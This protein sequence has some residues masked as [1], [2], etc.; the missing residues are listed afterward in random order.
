MGSATS[1]RAMPDAGSRSRRAASVSDSRI[2]PTIAILR[3]MSCALLLGG[4]VSA[5]PLG[6]QSDSARRTQLPYAP[7]GL[8]FGAVEEGARIFTPARLLPFDHPESLGHDF[9]TVQQLHASEF[10]V[11]LW[12]GERIG[13]RL[14]PTLERYPTEPSRTWP[15]PEFR[16]PPDSAALARARRVRHASAKSPLPG[17]RAAVF[18]GPALVAFIVDTRGMSL[19]SRHMTRATA[20]G[21]DVTRA[22]FLAAIGKAAPREGA[23]LVVVLWPR[24][25]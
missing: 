4:L 22:E 18:D 15:Y 16:P 14:W 19:A 12:L 2:G 9:P 3:V 13:L 1:V 20:M 25:P 6:A 21:L 24:E 10:P 17:L 23:G 7:V 5:T 8:F 11:L